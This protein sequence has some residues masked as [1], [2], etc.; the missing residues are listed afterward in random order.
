M[1]GRKHLPDANGVPTYR[2]TG[3]PLA[4]SH[5]EWWGRKLYIFILYII[6]IIIYIIYKVRVNLFSTGNAKSQMVRRYAGM[7]I[8][9][10][11]GYLRQ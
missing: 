2:R 9:C 5:G 10:P 1:K 11:Q 8:T 6:Y 7:P 4:K 3:V